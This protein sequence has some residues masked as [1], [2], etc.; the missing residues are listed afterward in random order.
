MPRPNQIIDPKAK[1]PGSKSPK[2]T[3]RGQACAPKKQG[4]LQSGTLGNGCPK[5]VTP[6]INTGGSGGK[7]GNMQRNQGRV[8]A[9][10][11]RNRQ[12]DPYGW[13]GS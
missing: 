13:G 3:N 1:K 7:S 4:Q 12:T 6:N 9:R 2:Q 8:G 11:N 5:W 10:N